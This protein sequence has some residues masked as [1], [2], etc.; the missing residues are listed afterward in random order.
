MTAFP[1]FSNDGPTSPLIEQVVFKTLR[2]EFENGAVQTKKKYLYPRRN[3]QLKFNVLT[4]AN[5]RTLYNFYIARGG[6][7]DQF[8][9]FHPFSH[10]YVGEYVGVGDGSSIN[11]N[12]PC[13]ESSS[14]T[15][16][17]DGFEQGGTVSTSSPSASPSSSISNSPSSSAS[18]SPSVSSSPSASASPSSSPSASL[19]PSGDDYIITHNGGAD[20]ADLITFAAA[21]SS[22]AIITMDFTGYL[23]VVSRF[24]MDNLGYENFKNFF[25]NTGMPIKGQLNE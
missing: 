4:P 9:F 6:S 22:G 20:G 2:T 1:T 11:F 14:V 23:K 15:V 8:N 3:F 18:L 10:A 21:P 5:A 24:A 25:I 7:F 17:V 12:A 19:I 13:K 16:Y